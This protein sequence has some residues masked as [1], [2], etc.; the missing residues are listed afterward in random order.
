MHLSPM[1]V[2]SSPEDVQLVPD[3]SV[4]FIFSSAMHLS[5]MMFNS[6]PEDVQLVP[7]ISIIFV[8]SSAMH[9]S[10]MMFNSSPED[11]CMVMKFLSNSPICHIT[12]N[13][14]PQLPLPR[15]I[16]FFLLFFLAV[17]R[18]HRIHMFLGLLDP[19]PLVRGMDPDQTS[20]NSKKNPN[21]YCFVTSFGLFIFEK[22]K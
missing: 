15:W 7:D 14:F 13:T 11:V 1:M 8:F 2:N 3:I 9:L 4:I 20:K 21:S 10:P 17:F 18:I 12:A 6:S 5:P 16:P 22:K 19:D